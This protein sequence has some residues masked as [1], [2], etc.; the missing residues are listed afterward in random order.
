MTT[1]R[2]AGIG[3]IDLAGIDIARAIFEATGGGFGTP[4]ETQPAADGAPAKLPDWT[5]NWGNGELK[6]GIDFGKTPPADRDALI[7]LVAEPEG[8][9]P[10]F[11]LMQPAA[12]PAFPNGGP[13][14]TGWVVVAAAVVIV[15]AAALAAHYLAGSFDDRP[16]PPKKPHGKGH[17]SHKMSIWEEEHS[18]KDYSDPDAEAAP[19]TA[20]DAMLAELLGPSD[21]PA[22]EA[23]SIA[24]G[25]LL[26][27]LSDRMGKLAGFVQALAGAARA[28]AGEPAGGAAADL[29][30][31]AGLDGFDFAAAGSTAHNF[32]VGVFTALG[33]AD[34]FGGAEIRHARAASDADAV[35][36][37]VAALAERSEQVAHWLNV[38][39]CG[40]PDGKPRAEGDALAP[41]AARR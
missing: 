33:L 6:L 5:T 23:G 38:L 10:M 11:D 29:L 27:D 34:G 41:P 9:H 35:S 20:P 15:G 32:A 24:I 36:P 14:G 1:T 8:S 12:E 22:V 39:A 26:S 7:K 31:F 40:A 19:L 30:A 3:G 18:S 2:P 21:V 25:D 16:E 4:R 37:E 28:E 17:G 13:E